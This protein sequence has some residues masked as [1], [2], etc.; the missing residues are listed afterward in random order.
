MIRSGDKLTK[1]V[2]CFSDPF[3]QL[4]HQ[5]LIWAM[6][7]YITSQKRYGNLILREEADQEAFHVLHM[8]C[9]LA[10][11]KSYHP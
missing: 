7:L 5:I 4:K 1:H 8:F 11:L 3:H 10:A 6:G 9:L 2:V